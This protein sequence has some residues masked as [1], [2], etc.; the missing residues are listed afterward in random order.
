M[1]AL[2]LEYSHYPCGYGAADWRIT[3]GLGVDWKP[4]RRNATVDTVR[5][6]PLLALLSQALVGFAAEYESRVLSA[7][8]VG[9]YLDACFVHG[10]LPLVEVPPV[11]MITGNGKSSLERHGAVQVD[12]SKRVT[13]TP[14]GRWLRDTYRPTVEAIESSWEA[15]APLRAALERIG[16]QAAR[17]ADHPD[18]RYAGGHVGFAEVS[19]RV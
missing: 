4:V 1:G 5:G 14:L 13:L 19:R 17:H 3:G 10:S 11:L 8:V 6:L 15:A 2:P 18:V 7:M 16:I 12:R 9:V